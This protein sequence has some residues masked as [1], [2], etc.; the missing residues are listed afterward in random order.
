MV[1][2]GGRRGLLLA[3][4]CIVLITRL[5]GR[6]Q[7]GFRSNSTL[8]SPTGVLLTDCVTLSFYKVQHIT[9]SRSQPVN[10]RTREQHQVALL[11]LLEATL[12]NCKSNFKFQR[13]RIFLADCTNGHAYAT[14]VHLSSVVCD[15]YYVLWLNGAS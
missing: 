14:V 10:S 2:R 3:Q 6:R 11:L 4:L 1:L 7:I 8:H 5:R 13:T 12:R 9:I 15:V